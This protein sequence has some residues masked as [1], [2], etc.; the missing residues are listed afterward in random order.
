MT[1]T[2]TLALAF[3]AWR[4]LAIFAAVLAVLP[5]LTP[6]VT[7]PLP[8]AAQDGAG[9]ELI[10][11][12]SA[13][14]GPRWDHTLA[15]DDEGGQLLVFGGRDG[16]GTAY[17]DTWLY[18]LE[19]GEWR[20]V[21]SPGPEP[22]FGQ[23]VAVD[24]EERVLYLHGG[25]AGS[26]F[27]DDTWTF[28]FADEAWTRL[29]TSAGP[30][31]NARY[32]HGAVL[33]GDGHLLITHGFTFAGRFDDTWSLDLDDLVW[34]DVSPDAG[35]VRP[36]PRCLFESIWDGETEWLVLF[37][38]CASGFGPCPLGDLWAYDPATRA[39]TEL[40]PAAGPSPRSN[41]ALVQDVEGNRAWLIGGLTDAGHS[42]DLWQLALDNADAAWTELPSG[43]GSGPSPRSSHDATLTAGRVYLFGGTGPDGV[44]ADL[45]TA[46]LE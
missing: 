11:D 32:G 4:R 16:A 33:D 18:D 3:A 31:P 14:P 45:W 29:D 34:T 46:E 20:A 21:E 25:E 19:A 9:W 27:Y 10:S 15:A 30:V 35:A 26:T 23:A 36:L 12:G 24:Q 5:M 17:G 1:T 38:G 40:T 28:R 41:P 2:S 8:A 22:R 43:S 13:G 39:W 7:R 44:F 6:T 37:G 42:A